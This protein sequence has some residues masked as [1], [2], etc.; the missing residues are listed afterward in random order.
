LDDTLILTEHDP[1]YT[2]GRLG[3]RDSLRVNEDTLRERSIPVVH[4]DRGGGITYHGP[5]QAVL[6]PIIDLC[7][8]GRDLHSYMRG[9][10]SV[11]IGF[12]ARYGV[13]GRRIPGM[14]GVWVG[15]RKIASIGTGTRRWVTFHGISLNI[16]VDLGCFSLIEPCGLKG[17]EMTSLER[18]TGSAVDAR[19][20]TAA[21]I[22]SFL[23]VFPVNGGIYDGCEAAG[24]CRWRG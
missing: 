15:R 6:Y 19:S 18:E 2:V 24:P 3:L 20:A 14:T 11:A 1:V 4:T 17:V 21:I 23:D 22:G 9:L 12:L 10:E 5:G 7:A 8:R 16:S 13:T